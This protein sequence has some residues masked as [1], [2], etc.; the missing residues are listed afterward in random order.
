MFEAELI[1]ATGGKSW[2]MWL[3]YKFSGITNL[4][5]ICVDEISSRMRSF[6]GTWLDEINK[7]SKLRTYCTIKG[8]FRCEDYLDTLQFNYGRQLTKLCL[9]AHMLHVE[10]GRHTRPIT[11]VNDRRC[12]ECATGE[13]EDEYHVIMK[14]NKY[15]NKRQELLNSV[16]REC[17]L[18]TALDESSKFFLL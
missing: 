15:A 1:D 8:N 4:T 9:S 11:S 6:E 13:M 12:N 18:F 3:K 7:N 17:P 16:T 14:C 5:N 2:I 10:T